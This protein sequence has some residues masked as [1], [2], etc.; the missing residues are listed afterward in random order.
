[1]EALFRIPKDNLLDGLNQDYNRKVQRRTQVSN[2]GKD[3]YFQ[4]LTMLVNLQGV[5]VNTPQWFQ[6]KRTVADT[7]EDKG[8]LE[9]ILIVRITVKAVVEQV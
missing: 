4:L 8:A 7:H 9:V 1:M 6:T 2:K 3:Q 5:V